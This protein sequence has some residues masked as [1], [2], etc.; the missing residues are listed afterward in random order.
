MLMALG[1]L[2]AAWV[3]LAGPAGAMDDPTSVGPN[4][5]NNST[6]SGAAHAANDS[7]ASGNATAINGSTS[8]GCATAVNESTASG[9]DCRPAA[10]ERPA[11]A[12][13]QAT[14]ATSLAFTGAGT[15]PL[16]LAAAGFV[17]LGTVLV[18]GSRRGQLA[19]R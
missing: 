11:A 15:A 17:L 2:L 14:P 3:L 13:A 9:G 7:T 16:A 19:Q 6:S 5:I 12:V 10:V 8:S 1:G 18:V 4:A